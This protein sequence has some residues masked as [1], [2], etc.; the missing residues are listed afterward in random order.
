MYRGSFVTCKHVVV[1]R[2]TCYRLILDGCV[3]LSVN[4]LLAVDSLVFTDFDLSN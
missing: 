4:T 2:K 3:L 1:A